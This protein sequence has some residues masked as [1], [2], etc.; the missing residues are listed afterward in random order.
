MCR[1][2]CGQMYLLESN[3]TSLRDKNAIAAR[4]GELLSLMKSFVL[5]VAA[6]V[7]IISSVSN[8]ELSLP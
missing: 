1:D 7:A 4:K 6:L 8:L 5:P 2:P 3:Q